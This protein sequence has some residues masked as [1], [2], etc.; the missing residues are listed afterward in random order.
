MKEAS[1]IEKITDTEFLQRE[2]QNLKI[3]LKNAKYEISIKTAEHNI[4]EDVLSS[5][6]RKIEAQLNNK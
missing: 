6:I 1:K 2:L 4:K 3:E 5:Q